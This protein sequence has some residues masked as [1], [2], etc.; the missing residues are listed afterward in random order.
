ML[1]SN[2]LYPDAEQLSH[3]LASPEDGPF[4]MVNLLRF[5]P[6]ATYPDGSDTH[7]TGLEAYARYGDAVTALVEKHGGRVLYSG[8]VTNLMIGTCDPLW[9]VVALVEYPSNAA[10]RAMVSSPEYRTAELHRSAGLEGQL[11]I[12]TKAGMRRPTAT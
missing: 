8:Q 9:D 2:A 6:K 7:L 1:A 5:K 12:R 11:N 4:T 10:F 3:F